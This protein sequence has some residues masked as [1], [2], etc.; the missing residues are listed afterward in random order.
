MSTRTTNSTIVLFSIFS[1]LAWAGGE[2]E[3]AR[4]TAGAGAR[5]LAVSR[6]DAWMAVA[7]AR[8]YEDGDY[9]NALAGYDEVLKFP[10]SPLYDLA[11]FKTAWC[12]W[13]LGDSDRAARRFKEVLDLGSGKDQRA[14]QLTKEGRK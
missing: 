9:K 8:F 13:K 7:E 11:L 3:E 2:Y 6:D 10:D 14:D 5:D 12:Y 4:L 1:S